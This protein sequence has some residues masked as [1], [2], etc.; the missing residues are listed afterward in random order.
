MPLNKETKPNYIWVFNV[1]LNVSLHIYI[2]YRK[3]DN[4]E[5]QEGEIYWE[6][7]STL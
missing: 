1:I 5:I 6:A 3:I 7:K 2:I 4:K